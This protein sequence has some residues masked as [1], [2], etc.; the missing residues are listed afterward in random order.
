MAGKGY[1]AIVGVDFN[2]GVTVPSKDVEISLRRHPFC[3]SIREVRPQRYRQSETTVLLPVRPGRRTVSQS[4]KHGNDLRAQADDS[5]CTVPAFRRRYTIRPGVAGLSARTTV[6]FRI[7]CEI[8]AR[9]VSFGRLHHRNFLLRVFKEVAVR[10]FALAL[11][12]GDYCRDRSAVAIRP[13]LETLQPSALQLRVPVNG[14]LLI[15]LTV[16]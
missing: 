3:F 9:R 10:L 2:I 5:V 13:L 12:T 4:L 15:F 16:S 8:R 11:T 1:A 14:H 7:R 6:L